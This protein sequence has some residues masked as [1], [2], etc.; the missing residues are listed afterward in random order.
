MQT[1]CGFLKT[2]FPSLYSHQENDSYLKWLL[3]IL[4][5]QWFLVSLHLIG[6]LELGVLCHK[7]LP[8]TTVGV[9]LL[10]PILTPLTFQW[11]E[12]RPRTALCSPNCQLVLRTPICAGRHE[13]PNLPEK[14][15]ENLLF[16]R[17]ICGW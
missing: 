5:S 9:A 7:R 12:N 14:G 13:A 1:A 10:V 16:G 11:S 4:G 17:N 15:Q 8:N 6:S 2:V 3:W